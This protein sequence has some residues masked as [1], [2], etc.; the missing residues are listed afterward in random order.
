MLIDEMMF[1]ELIDVSRTIALGYPP[2]K[3]FNL[4]YNLRGVITQIRSNFSFFFVHQFIFNKS[5][6]A[7]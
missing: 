2:H 6:I 4:L 3:K 7:Q 1:S 5:A